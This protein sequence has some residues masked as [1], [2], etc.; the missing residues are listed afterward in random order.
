MP[1]HTKREQ[2]KKLILKRKKDWAKTPEKSKDV[3]RRKRD[4]VPWTKVIIKK[5]KMA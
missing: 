2:V 3:M 1:K 4:N 5:T